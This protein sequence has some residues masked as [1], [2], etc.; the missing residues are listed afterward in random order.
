MSK[1]VVNGRLVALTSRGVNAKP[2][3][4]L[5]RRNMGKHVTSSADRRPPQIG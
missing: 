2:A 5:H 4:Q 1:Q 3:G